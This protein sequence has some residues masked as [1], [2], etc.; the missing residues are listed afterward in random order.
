MKLPQPDVYW[1]PLPHDAAAPPPRTTPPRYAEAQA[2]EIYDRVA[3]GSRVRRKK[4]TRFPL[5]GLLLGMG[6]LLL[7][8][9][10]SPLE[11][12][13]A[14]VHV[15]SIGLAFLGLGYCLKWMLG[16]SR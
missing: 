2:G 5:Q 7:A 16:Y 1:Q 4:R 13:K 14:L 10:I 12:N 9:V 8:G 15:P 3:R 6:L 11:I